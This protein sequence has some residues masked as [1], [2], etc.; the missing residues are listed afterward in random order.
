MIEEKIQTMTNYDMTSTKIEMKS[1][2][3]EVLTASMEEN[4]SEDSSGKHSC[5]FSF[6]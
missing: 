2:S 6:Q 5:F 4:S 3:S 1:N